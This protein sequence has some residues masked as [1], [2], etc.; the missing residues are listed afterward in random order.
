MQATDVL[1]RAEKEIEIRGTC[2]C[3]VCVCGLMRS[4]KSGEGNTERK[5]MRAQRLLGLEPRAALSTAHDRAHKRKE[6]I[7]IFRRRHRTDLMLQGCTIQNQ[8]HDI[9]PTVK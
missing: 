7:R 6:T 2:A 1:V 5:N 3:V 4:E 9:H 8:K